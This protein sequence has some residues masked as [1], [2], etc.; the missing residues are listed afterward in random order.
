MHALQ[1][2]NLLNVIRKV[3]YNCMPILKINLYIFKAKKLKMEMG[4]LPKRPDRPKSRKYNK[5]TNES[6]AQPENPANGG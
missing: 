3:E 2:N 5:V 6:S 4:N 1:R